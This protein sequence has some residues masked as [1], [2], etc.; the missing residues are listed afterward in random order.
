MSTDRKQDVKV[1]RAAVLAVERSILTLTELTTAVPATDWGVDLIAFEPHPFRAVP[2]QVKGASS[3]LKV[4]RKYADRP[5]IVAY[6]LRPHDADSQVVIMT[7]EEA[8][9]LPDDYIARGGA[10]SDFHSGLHDYRWPGVT[11]LHREMLEPMVAT[12]DR[13]D[14]LIAKTAIS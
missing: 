13:W 6:V 7:G 11:A 8:W 3:G 4:F 2:I 10:A 9:Q 12:R 14:E 1:E 5:I